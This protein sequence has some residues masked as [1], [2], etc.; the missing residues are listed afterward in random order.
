MERF[1]IPGKNGYEIPVK[2]CW[3]GEKQV[4]IVC[5]GFGSSK[6]SPMVQALDERMP[7]EGIGT[8]SF[9]FPAH[10][11]SPGQED[12][13][14]VP[15]CMDDLA[16]VE[17]Y[18]RSQDPEVEIGYFGSSFG[19]YITLL[20]LSQHPHPGAK[21]FLRSSAVTMPEL[22]KTWLDQR[23]KEDLARQGWFVPDYDYV[24]EMRITPAFLGD[25]AEHD[26]FEKYVPGAA[27]LRMIHGAKDDV[28][29]TGAAREFA[30]RFGAHLT[31]LPNGEHPLMGPGELET[32]L[33]AAADFF[34]K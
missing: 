26:L 3:T 34:S 9:D 23:A 14:R 32:V 10:G 13:L 8:V 20:Y 2:S 29:P 16:A 21:V 27:T 31:V 17:E 19:A 25:L 5:H 18:V 6:E 22:V 7:R 28:A 30:R 24:R 1:S 15:Y 11:E 4:L 33:D 12:T